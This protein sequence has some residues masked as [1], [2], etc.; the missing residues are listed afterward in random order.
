MYPELNLECNNQGQL[1]H[2]VG[3]G[4]NKKRPLTLKFVTN[5]RETHFCVTEKQFK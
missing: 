5:L 4:R 2:L 1:K 3:P